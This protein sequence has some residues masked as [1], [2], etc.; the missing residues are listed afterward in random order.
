MSKRPGDPGYAAGWCIHYRYNRNVKTPAQDT[1]EAGVRY[2]KFYGIKFAVRPCF[3][4]DKGQSKPDALLCE[5]LRRPT[6][7]EIGLH[8]KV[9]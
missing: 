5:H 2:D 6:K 1:C 9:V 7:E 4:D 3:L 8:E